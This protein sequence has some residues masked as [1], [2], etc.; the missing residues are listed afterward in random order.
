MKL[1]FIWL[2]VVGKLGA[3]VDR[4]T[5]AMVEEEDFTP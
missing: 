3:D 1:D 4:F 5:Q 2:G